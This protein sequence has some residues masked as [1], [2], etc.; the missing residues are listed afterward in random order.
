MLSIDKRKEELEKKRAKLAELRRAREERK[1]ALQDAVHRDSGAGHIRDRRDIDEL[2]ASLVGDKPSSPT[3]SLSASRSTATPSPGPVSQP[4]AAPD[5][6][7]VE[8][9]PAE[10]AAPAEVEEKYVPSLGVSDFLIIDVAPKE[11]VKYN[12]EIQT[13]EIMTDTE[14]LDRNWGEQATGT[15]EV[16]DGDD[17]KDET[18]SVDSE[19]NVPPVELS[20]TERKSILTSD[21]FRDFFDHSSKLMERALN[22]SYDFMTDYTIGDTQTAD[23]GAG[24]D[25]KTVC[26]FFDDRLVRNRCVT[27][28]DWSP[29]YPELLLA[30]YNKNVMAVNEPDG[31]VLVWNTH[32]R[33][34][35]EF[36]FHSQSDVTAAQFS[37][38]HPNLIIGGTYSGQVVLWDTRAKSLPVLKTPLSAAGHTHPVHAMTMVGTQNAHN[39]VTASSDGLVC[40]WQLDMLAQP[41][42]TLDLIH[43]SHPKTDEVAVT[44]FG[45][46]ANETTTFWVGT[47]EG[48]V[49]Q[50]N[51]YERA[52]TKAGINPNDTY[53][54]HYGMITGLDFHPLHGPVDFSDLY[55]T[56]SV[57][58]TVKL[59]RV[60]SL[61]KAATAPQTIAP[62]YSF[63]HAI[64]YVYDARWSPL[65]PALF[66]SVDGMGTLDLYNLNTDVEVPIVTLPVT[67]GKALNKLKW[68]REGQKIAS[69]S[70]DGHVY[71]H[72]LGEIA[73]PHNEEWSQLQRTIA[74]LESADNPSSYH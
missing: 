6:T 1:A 46:P 59:W 27:D 50:A 74:E 63:E 62:L 53:K 60:K 66:G 49:Y 43:P 44:T 39:L 13:M 48:N 61:T 70:S 25:V 17:G 54:G 21:R 18:G 14:D 58:W 9:A 41:Q 67:N 38:F 35:P 37:E 24:T 73:Q 64:D 20:D 42:E 22:D 34:R 29:K 5:K 15:P 40:A 28:M 71:I 45:F 56:S 26:T 47:E 8:E 10:T 65:H 2:V 52:G 36:V 31:L 55:L 32:L 23:L 16:A 69:G 19:L 72:D 12:K 51:R 57:D 11:V 7:H 3:P 30:S 33:E 4:A 68:D